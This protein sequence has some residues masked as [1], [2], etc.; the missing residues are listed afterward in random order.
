M[1]VD[2]SSQVAIVTGGAAGI[3][4]AIA[5]VLAENGAQVVIV[6]VDAERARSTAS[7][8]SAQ[9]RS[10]VEMLADVANPAQM[11]EISEQVLSQFGRVDILVNNAGINTLR[12]RAPIHEYKLEDWDKILQ[13]DLTGV[14]VASRALVPAMLRNKRG[15]IVNISSIAGL[16]PLRLQSAFVA[17]KAGV[18]NLTRSMALELGP[19]GILVNAVAPGSTLTAGTEALFY[20]ADGS[21]TERA[22]SLLSHIPLGRPARP[23]EIASAVLFLVAPEA[24]YVNGAILTVDGG[25]TVGYTRDW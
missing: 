6:D 18:V 19:Q 16:V 1:N 9:G 8:I 13:V 11:A 24:S 14:F 23:E 3:G 12:D 25:W 17:A 2:L 5:S 21:Y 10:C 20:G 15:R 7:E 22:A 4:R